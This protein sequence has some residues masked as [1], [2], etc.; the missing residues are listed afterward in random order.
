MA[1]KSEETIQKAAGKPREKLGLSKVL[2]IDM[3]AVLEALPKIAP[4]FSFRPALAA[5]MGEDEAVMDD[6][7]HT[8]TARECVLEDAKEGKPRARFTI[9]HELGHYLLG[10]EGRRRRNSNKEVY[11]GPR[12]RIEEQEADLF[13][14]YLLVPNHLAQDV[15]CAEDISLCFRVSSMVAEIAFE[16]VAKAK[17]R[18]TG[19]KRRPV[20]VVVDFLKEAERHGYKVKS[21]ISDY[22]DRD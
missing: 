20:G 9:A 19:Q 3:Y 6:D 21:D 13:A 7:T 4:K 17:R 11:A 5:E 8:L 18:A 12:E 22:D 14:S 16:R 15:T 2:T 1:R 10:H